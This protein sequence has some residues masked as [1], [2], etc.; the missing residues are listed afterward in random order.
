MTY[1]QT[2]DYLFSQLPMYQRQGKVAFK[3]DLS[4]TIALCKLLNY[5]ERNFKSIHVAGTNGKGSVAHL[6]SSIF[7][8][9]GY[10]TALYTSPHLKDFRERIKV[11]GKLISKETVVEFVKTH[12]TNFEKIQPSFFEWSV[13]FAFSHF[14]EEKVDIAI[15]ETGLGGRLDS[16][17]VIN[18]ELSIITNIGLDHTDLLG[19]SLKEIAFEKAGI[20]KEHTP[21]LIGDACGQEATFNQLAKEKQAPIH[22]VI[23]DDNEPIYPTDLKGYYQTYNRRT[24]IAAAYIMKNAAWKIDDEIIKKAL[25]SVVKNTGLQGRW[26]QLKNKPKVIADTAHNKEGF[27]HLWKQLKEEQFNQL[28]FV[29]GFVK[30]RDLIDLFENFPKEAKYYFCQAKIP[31]AMDVEEV[32]KIAKL[33]HLNGSAYKSVKEAYKAALSAA[34][35]DDFIYIG[36]SN[37]V[38]AEVI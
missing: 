33:Q 11:D 19:N 16:T 6:L 3:K 10:K 23:N 35:A 28:H 26:Q 29:V 13:A 15:I 27:V 37:F 31:R 24:A 1:R 9:A 21:I 22:Y 38:V 18:P 8:T 32:Q 17:N 25:L 20:I 2:L 14:A 5:P 12:K 7:Q 36:G 34:S 30:E 4:K